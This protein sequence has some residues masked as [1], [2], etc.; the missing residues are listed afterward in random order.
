MA[1]ALEWSRNPDMWQVR[2]K[3]LGLRTAIDQT[4]ATRLKSSQ[5]RIER[6]YQQLC[7][8]WCDLIDDARVAQRMND[9]AATQRLAQEIAIFYQQFGLLEGRIDS[10][11]SE[12]ESLLPRA[13]TQ[14][15]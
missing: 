15:G 4:R 3:M 12:A 14:T 9:R 11:L 8:R 2:G 13:K 1:G 10:V 7:D 5:G 6:E